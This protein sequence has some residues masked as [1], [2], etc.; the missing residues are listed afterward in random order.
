MAHIIY[1]D[2]SRLWLG[3]VICI[4]SFIDAEFCAL[5]AIR[6]PS[7]VEPRLYIVLLLLVLEQ[8]CLALKYLT[9]LESRTVRSK[10]DACLL[11]NIL[12]CGFTIG[13]SLTSLGLYDCGQV[14]L[15][16]ALLVCGIVTH[17]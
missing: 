6:Q 9:L 13:S 11:W 16:S 12:L 2:T 10:V 14:G 5:L 3:G 4:C 15:I 8:A 1:L 17:F 7:E